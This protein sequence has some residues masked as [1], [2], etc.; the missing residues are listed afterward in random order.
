MMNQKKWIN[1][2]IKTTRF[3]NKTFIDSINNAIY[4]LKI[5]FRNERNF[6]FH[7]VAA[8]LIFIVSLFMDLS[9][10]EFLIITFTVSFVLFAE[11]IN[12]AIEAIVDTMIKVYHPKAK[13]IKDVAAAGVL[14]SSVNAIVVA[15]LIFV[16]RLDTGLGMVID[17]LRIY[18]PH[19]AL[20]SIILTVFVVILLKLLYNKGTPFKGGMPSG[21][22][23]VAFVITTSIALWFKDVIL[24][25]LCLGLS[26]LV[27][28]SRIEGKIHNGFEVVAGALVGI[29]ITIFV[30]SVINYSL[31]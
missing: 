29:L 28:Q 8:I 5:V 9:S 3:K 31:L 25:F 16:G 19:I 11:I 13:I 10:V 24:I 22:T 1:K 27:A 21:H 6:K 23:A 14:V 2:P 18:P 17:R 7:I 15:Y 30:F 20:I 4:G 12:T 26:L